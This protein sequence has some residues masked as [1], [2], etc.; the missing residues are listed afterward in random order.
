[1]KY[2]VYILESQKDG[3]YYIGYT[4]D[5]NKRLND[6]NSGKSR[7]TS[8]KT[9]WKLVYHEEFEAKSEAIRRERFL[10]NQKNRD[11]YMSLIKNWS[12]SSVG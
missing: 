2:W 10:K 8:R 7:Y 1:M 9:P 11:F 5:V 12:G 3:S 4:S 6:H